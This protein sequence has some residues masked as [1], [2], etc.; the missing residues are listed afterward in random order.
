MILIIDF[1]GEKSPVH[2]LRNESS[3][4]K[5]K[6]RRQK[7]R[8]MWRDVEWVQVGGQFSPPRDWKGWRWGSWGYEGVGLGA[9]GGGCWRHWK[10]RRGWMQV[11]LAKPRLLLLQLLRYWLRLQSAV[12]GNS[13]FEVILGFRLEHGFNNSLGGWEIIQN[14]KM[15]KEKPCE[16]LWPIRLSGRT[17]KRDW[18]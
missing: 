3:L 4:E 12:S 9:H 14:Y 17:K 7:Q 6:G 13:T 8:G 16:M 2:L 1:D 5:E 10:R 18:S 11:P 15:N